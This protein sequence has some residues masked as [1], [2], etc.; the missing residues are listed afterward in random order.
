[1]T[2]EKAYVIIDARYIE[3]C[4]AAIGESA[5]VLL[6]DREHPARKLLKEIE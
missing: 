2:A 5:E 1:M 6:C 3:A 4:R